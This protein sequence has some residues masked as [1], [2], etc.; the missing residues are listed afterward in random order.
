MDRTTKLLRIIVSLLLICVLLI[1]SFPFM[2]FAQAEDNNIASS[3]ERTIAEIGAGE[4]SRRAASFDDLPDISDEEINKTINRVFLDKKDVYLEI[5]G[6]H[7]ISVSDA[8]SECINPSMIFTSSDP[9]VASVSAAGQITAKKSGSALIYVNDRRTGKALTCSVYVGSGYAPTEQP[10]Q[11]AT[12]FPTDPPKPTQAP[13]QNPTQAP[14]QKPTQTPT[15]KPT[16][17]PTQKPTQAPT[18]K[19]TQPAEETLL[20]NASSA[21][22]YRGCYYHVV[23]KSNASVTFSSSNT[24]V[25]KVDSDGIV[26]A[27]AV[28]SATITAK[29]STKTASCKLIVITGSS[30]NISHTSATVDRFMTLLMKSSTSG[31]KWSSSDTSVATVDRGYVYGAKAGVAIITAST[32]NGAATCKMTVE[33]SFPIRFA[34]T[35]PNCAAKNQT[36]TLIAIT[37]TMRTAVRFAIGSGSSVKYIDAASCT[38]DDDTYIWKGT[39]SFSSSG[40]FSVKAYSKI[41]DS[42]WCTCKD[43]ETTAF[44]ADSTDMITTVCANRRASDDV[45]NLIATFEGF[46]KS[47]YDDPFTGDPTLGYGRV[48]YTGEEF[49]NNLTK[50]E[51]YAYLVQTVNNEGY[52]DKVNSF[53]VGNNIKFNQRQFDALVCFVYNTGTGPLYYDDDLI[54]ALLDCS[55][56]SGTKKTYYI[57]DSYVRL[58]KGPG[59]NYDIIKELSYGTS[60]TV[61]S[62][63]NSEWYYVELSDGTKGYVYSEYISSRASGGNLDFNYI[64]KQNFINK[65]CQYHHAGGGCVYGLLYRR[66][67]ETEIFFYGEYEPCYG[68]YKYPINFVCANNPSFHT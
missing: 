35:S 45:I 27:L 12:E 18:Q 53:L 61:L 15:Q 11:S 37:D 67:D 25:A 17:A 60:V 24:S 28:G 56:G 50:A 58:R 38:K 55:D 23:A 2:I 44:V 41:G 51:A 43:A 21:T 52:S 3:G 66:V 34:Y 13:T 47:A 29:T 59:T 65:L 36:V 33:P 42:A 26:T 57:N 4:D 48:V 8:Y 22:V 20:I 63:S 39:T 54:S 64:N 40:T 7:Q 9:A 68:Y 49:Y 14:T 1:S 30:V 46:L 5:N 19:P 32:T 6:K 31:V 16:Q 10:T 62:T